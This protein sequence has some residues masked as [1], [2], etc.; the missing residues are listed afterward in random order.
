MKSNMQD[1]SRFCEVDIDMA[2]DPEAT[3]P[4]LVE[5][6]KTQVTANRKSA[7]QNRGAKFAADR[8]NDQEQARVDATYGW[9]ASPISVAR[10]CAEL[11]EQIKNEDWSFVSFSR[12]LSRWPQR[13]WQFEKQYHFNGGSGGI[14]IGYNAPAAV[15]AALANRKHGRLSVNIQS[16]GDLMFA[17]GVLWTA[18]HHRI[19]ILNIMHNNRAYFAEMMQ[20]QTIACEHNRGIDRAHLVTSFE[21][22]HI[23]FA[24]IAQGMGVYAEG[25]ITNPDDLGPAIRRA[26]AVVK[27][28]EPALVDAVCQ[29]R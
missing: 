18:A 27:G 8:Q 21:N 29:G 25:P 24:K 22:P 6:V 11:W 7:F 28:G 20:F 23:D 19:P 5:A 3:M 4:S 17:P 16:D 13:L 15:G 12:Y 26:I 9:G 2:A 10:L 14:G 1:L